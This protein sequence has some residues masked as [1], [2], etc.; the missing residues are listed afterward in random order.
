MPR[1][2]EWIT[3]FIMGEFFKY[4]VFLSHSARELFDVI[5]VRSRRERILATAMEKSKTQ[6][7]P[8]DGF[9]IDGLPG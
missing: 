4:D 7:R 8:G 3:L 9:F 1:M 2:H 6:M 5:S